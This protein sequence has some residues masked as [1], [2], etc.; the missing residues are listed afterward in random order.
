MATGL[1][2]SPKLDTRDYEMIVA[3]ARALAPLYA[4]EWNTAEENSAGATLLRIVARLLE[5]IIRRLNDVPLKNF[6]A[7][8]ESIGIKLLPAL[9]A[10]APITFFLSKGAKDAVTIPARSQVAAKPPEGPPPTTIASY[11]SLI[12]RRLWRR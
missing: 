12:R 3:R 4:A 6:I 10:R 7:F 11:V 1:V 5:G 2:K 8:L 9:P